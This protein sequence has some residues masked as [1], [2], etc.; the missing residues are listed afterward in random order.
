M[1]DLP[2]TSD[3]AVV[4][5]GP[6]GLAVATGL[7]KRGVARVI[8]LEREA[9]AGGI[10]RHCGHY[11]FGLGT[12]GRLMKG[13]DF[14]RRCVETA[15]A[16]GVEIH[17]RTTVTALHP[18][19][20]LSLSTPGGTVELHAERVVLCTGV[21]EASRAQRFIGGA[22]PGGV[23][24]TGALQSMI[25]LHGLR[26]FSRPVI[27]GSEL[28]SFSAI[29]TCRHL[30]IRPA[31]MI[32]AEDRPRVRRIMWPYLRLRR[33]PLFTGARG[34]R[35]LGHRRVEAVEFDSPDGVQR[36][37][38]DGVI[39][40]G[41]FRSEAAL[42]RLGHLDVDP[43]SGGPVVDQFGRCSDP[44][45]FSA[46]NLL[47][48]AETSGWC[49]REGAET[50]EWIA[51]DLKAGRGGTQVA[52]TTTDPAIAFALPQRLTL[53]EPGGMSR[54]LIGLNAPL[55]GE[56]RAHSEGRIVTRFPINSRP[57]RRIAL[58]LDWIARAAP[59]GDITLT[60]HED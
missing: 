31:A 48:P 18:G 13:P 40:S 57:L 14:A 15:R 44:A 49:W 35:I 12:F 27:L 34:L 50:A 42:L 56:I 28:V 20:R 4:G 10:P 24:S 16:A 22:R 2:D 8:V 47:R 33:V 5:G 19:G 45:Y 7:R 25:Y 23:L 6:A 54:L 3:V 59:S 60:T 51:D 41:R 39:L 52:L 55:R 1:A 29:Q 46:G 9:D 38:C 36:V 58:P 11:P 43:G 32:E 37:A 30:G 17:T 21:R 53:N 26:P